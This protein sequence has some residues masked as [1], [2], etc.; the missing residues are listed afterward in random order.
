VSYNLPENIIKQKDLNMHRAR[1]L[2]GLEQDPHGS[3]PAE[4]HGN[5]KPGQV[6]G[7]NNDG[8]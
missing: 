2:A 7:H 6:C 5:C 3:G 1:V 4:E 8:K